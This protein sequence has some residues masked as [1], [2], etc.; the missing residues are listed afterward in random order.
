[1]AG[2]GGNDYRVLLRARWVLRALGYGSVKEA[3]EANENIANEFMERKVALEAQLS[4]WYVKAK[5]NLR[6]GRKDQARSYLE[7]IKHA[8]P[9]SDQA[10]RR[11]AV[12][13]LRRL[14][15]KREN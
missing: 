9:Q 7:R 6:A 11:W 2:V 14:G 15:P 3:V 12:Q 1:M 4:K 5:E 10:I 8:V 13:R